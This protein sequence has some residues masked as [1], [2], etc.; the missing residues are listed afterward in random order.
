MIGQGYSGNE[1]L[2]HFKQAQSQVRPAVEEMIGEAERVAVAKSEYESYDD[3]F[4][5]ENR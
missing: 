5:R 2:Q 1:L 4:S 3:V